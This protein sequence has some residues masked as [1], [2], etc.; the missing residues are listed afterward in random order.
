[1]NSTFARP[2]RCL[3]ALLGSLLAGCATTPEEPALDTR[4]VNLRFTDAT[5]FETAA[6]A[7][8]RLENI[9]PADLEVTGAAHKLTVNGRK[10]G[11][12]LAAAG[13][14]VPRLGSTTQSVEVH[15]GNFSMARTLEEISRSH[16][17]EWELDSTIYVRPPG[18]RER[19]VRVHRN[20]N[21]DLNRLGLSGA[22][23][24]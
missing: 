22:P 18:G 9:S 21:L 8:V 7:E 2:L 1:M 12:G 5:V 13:V 15:L 19:T 6:I 11:R 17:V 23:G 3:A 14:T 10:L 20:G 4:L 16:V 24:R